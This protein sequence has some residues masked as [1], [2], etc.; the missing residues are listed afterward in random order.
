MKH[1]TISV[2][3]AVF[4]L[5][6]CIKPYQ[7]QIT[8]TYTFTGSPQSFT[9]PS[10]VSTLSLT[11][12]GAR[13]GSNAQ[14]VLGGLGG[15]AYGELSVSPG[16][17]LTIYV[18]GNNGYNGGGL[19]GVSPCTAAIG[20]S[21]GGGSDVR[22][23]GNSL[24]NRVIVGGGGGG[25]GG[26]RT[27]GC[28]RGT[29]GGG[30]GGYYGGGGGAG[31]PSNGGYVLPT[32]GTQVAGGIGGIS[33]AWFA[34]NGFA[35]ALWTGGAGGYEVSSNQGMTQ[36]SFTGGTGGGLIGGPGQYSVWAGEIYANGCGGSG[37]GGSSYIG[38]LSNAYTLP[39]NNSGNGEVIISY[40]TSIG[41]MPLNLMQT[42][43]CT[44]SSATLNAAG[45]V[46][47]TWS[48]GSNLSGIVVSPTVN[49]TYSVSGTNSL[50]CVS[51]GVV[52]LNVDGN[53]PNV[54]I[55]A[56]SNSVCEGNPVTLSGTGANSYTW[57]GG[58]NN[59]TPFVPSSTSSY[60]V[61]GA[62]SCGT[63]TALVT[64][65]VNPN[66]SLTVSP[67]SVTLCP[68]NS[69]TLTASG[70]SSYTWTGGII[71]GNAFVPSS[72]N[73]YSVT[74]TN[75]FGCIGTSTAAVTLLQGP[76]LSP[77]A[78]PPLI[79]V[80]ETSSISVTGANNYTWMP[81]GSNASSITVSPTITTVYSLTQ[82]IGSCVDVKTVA[83][84]VNGLPVVSASAFPSSI[85]PL[86]SSTLSA[87]GALNYTWQPYGGAGATAVVSPTASTVFTLSVSDGTCANSATLG[88]IVNPNP[89]LSIAA[90]ASSVCAGD[91]ATLTI[92]G[93]STYTWIPIASTG[94]VITVNPISSTS[95]SVTGTSSLGCTSMVSQIIHVNPLPL[96]SLT[97]SHPLVCQGGSSTLSA[98]GAN[99][100]TWTG[101][102]TS[103]TT[104]VNPT[105]TTTFSV[106]GTYTNTGC[107]ST[108]T[109]SV[110]VFDPQFT[111]TGNPAVCMGG[112][113]TLTA[114]GANTY[115]WNGNF[116]LPS[117]SV[118]PTVYT[119][120]QVSATSSS[121]NVTC[122][123]SKTIGVTVHPNPTVT[124]T[125]SRTF[126][127]KGE[128][129]VLSASGALTYT[130]NT[131]PPGASVT[132][133]PSSQ[134]N[135]TVTGTDANG[136]SNTALITVKVS[137]CLG[138]KEIDGIGDELL[139]YP[140]PNSGEFEIKSTSDINLRLVNALGQLIRYIQLN[141]LND[142]NES[143][144]HFEPGVY[145]V[146]GSIKNK[147]ITQKIIV[148]N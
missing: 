42:H 84:I 70:A 114:I 120:Y 65:S 73:I 99:S 106:M 50:G 71:N 113:T 54:S 83:V 92:S 12:K 39:G 5:L 91:P 126:I 38:G 30:G 78:S 123:S 122:S 140:N 109:I 142:H 82:S 14:G 55:F 146:V 3:S 88:L 44:G 47:Y 125:A 127:C 101:G 62:N 25:A 48:T 147:L 9:V 46:S 116:S 69:T 57:S 1:F 16:D 4:F 138:M 7:A 61:S 87:A 40:T 80:G 121:N 100:Y 81:G 24:A 76:S 94:S 110:A 97:A 22:L 68:G 133:A 137:A 18:G 89:S 136:C 107:A 60:T 102:F 128:S 52:T 96:I 135:Y 29:G 56:S 49:T 93:A 43:I 115:T 37:G 132:T 112:S 148:G 72:S 129:V 117:I 33:G 141:E 59:G 34:Y 118:S 104:V 67:G 103:P 111:I 15:T 41:A 45:Q 51:A 75:T 77:V 79:C 98:S 119:V 13:G 35:G 134:Q 139:I 17:V 20:G 23:N 90:S 2:F 63:G 26:N 27:L 108:Q 143:I 64:V 66:P 144:S 31:N 28:G 58:V 21:G 105:N 124:A 95:Y 130:W 131:F 11:A 10:C 85:C 145:F 32:G 74:G 36:N 19:A 8:L 86:G 53:L 6:L